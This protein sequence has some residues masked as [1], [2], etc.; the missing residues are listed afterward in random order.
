MTVVKVAQIFEI[1]N[2][3]EDYINVNTSLAQCVKDSLEQVKDLTNAAPYTSDMCYTDAN[4]VLSGQDTSLN[5]FTNNMLTATNTFLDACATALQANK[6]A[7]SDASPS[8]TYLTTTFSNAQLE[9]IKEFHN[10]LVAVSFTVD[11]VQQ[12]KWISTTGE[13]VANSTIQGTTLYLITSSDAHDFNVGVSSNAALRKYKRVIEHLTDC[14]TNVGIMVSVIK[15]KYSNNSNF[16][17]T[18]I[19]TVA[20][21]LTD[22]INQINTISNDGREW[23]NK[24]EDWILEAREGSTQ[25]N[26]QQASMLAALNTWRNDFSETNTDVITDV[27]ISHASNGGASVGDVLIGEDTNATGNLV[28]VVTGVNSDGNVTSLEIIDRGSGH[29]DS[30]ALTVYLNGSESTAID[31]AVNG[32]SSPN[33][34]LGYRN[35][36]NTNLSS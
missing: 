4:T 8:Y 34:W 9:F 22:L 21:N 19:A 11:M 35:T 26:Y 2:G 3:N 15:G 16:T 36:L 30:T 32:V 18:S 10:Y 29:T 13:V 23:L 24:F 6:A 1:V 14:Y 25:V 27:T 7:S 33:S 28:A 5:D 31:L 12:P 17:G 20:S